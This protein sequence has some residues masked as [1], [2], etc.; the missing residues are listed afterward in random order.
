MTENKAT[1]KTLRAAGAILAR[2]LGAFVLDAS[3]RAYAVIKNA[4][5]EKKEKASGAA[6]TEKTGVTHA[7][8]DSDGEKKPTA[9]VG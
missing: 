1:G 8:L 6:D 2:D 7:T 4:L 5:T 9:A 3:K